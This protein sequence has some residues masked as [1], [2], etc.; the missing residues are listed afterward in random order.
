MGVKGNQAMKKAW[1]YLAVFSILAGLS[2]C[3]DGPHL[4]VHDLVVFWNEVCDNMLK[5]TNED[6]AKDLVKVE[7]ML[8]DK[9]FEKIKERVERISREFGKAEANDLEDAFLD[10]CDEIEATEKRLTNCQARLKAIID[11]SSSHDNLAK[12]L[13]WPAKRKAFHTIALGDYM[14]VKDLKDPLR[15]KQFGN[16]MFPA[17]PQFKKSQ[18]TKAK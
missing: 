8:L 7:F 6:I 13:D 5:A 4:V 17:R 10:Y 18:T 16:G 1:R 15:P 9:K 3:A 12:I 14:P 11:A 2:G